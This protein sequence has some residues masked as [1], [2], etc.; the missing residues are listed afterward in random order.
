MESVSVCHRLRRAHA[1]GPRR[2]TTPIGASRAKNTC[3]WEGAGRLL[4]ARLCGNAVSTPESDMQLDRQA[5][6]HA[7][8]Y[9]SFTMIR[10]AR[11]AFRIIAEAL[12]AAM[13]ASFV[14][15]VACAP[16]LTVL[17]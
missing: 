14:G 2:S 16:W 10:S 7:E 17:K 9:S 4:D 8:A 3:N 13:A 15:R 6:F 1:L 11:I 12:F 5:R